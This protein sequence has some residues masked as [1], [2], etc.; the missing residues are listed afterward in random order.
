MKRLIVNADD[1]GLTKGVSQTI[2]VVHT[3]GIISSKS[4]RANGSAF[5]ESLTLARKHLSLEIGAH[6][7]EGTG[8]LT[9]YSEHCEPA[10]LD[11]RTRLLSERGIELEALTPVEIKE[12]VNQQILL[13][14]YRDL[15]EAS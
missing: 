5:E 3:V 6:L 9:C 13:D 8:E 2:F 7:P 14:T 4:L 15:S 1:S 11:A 12:L 10:H